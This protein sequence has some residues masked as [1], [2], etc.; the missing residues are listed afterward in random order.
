MRKTYDFSHSRSNPYAERLNVPMTSVI[1]SVPVKLESDSA[2]QNGMKDANDLHPGPVLVKSHIP[3]KTRLQTKGIPKQTDLF[4]ADEAIMSHESEAFLT[5]QILTYIGNKRTLLDF[6]GKGVQRAMQDLGKERLDI[7]DVFAGSGIVSRYLKQFSNTLF[8]C[9]LEPYSA[10]IN[11]CYLSNQSEIDSAL[12]AKAIKTINDAAKKN[13]RPGF[14][15][16]LYAPQN[17]QDIKLGERVFYTRR[18]AM[19]IDTSRQLIEELLPPEMQR[20]ALAPLLYVASVH[21][22]TSGVFKGFYKNSETGIGQ[23]GGNGKD[24]LTRICKDFEIPAPLFSQHECQYRVYQGNSNELAKTIPNIDLAYLDPPYNQHPY[25]SNYF[26]LNLIAKNRR[27]DE[28]SSVSGI[29]TDWNR[30]DYNKRPLAKKALRE[31]VTSIRAKYLLISFNSEGFIKHEEMK[32]MLSE[33]GT[34]ESIETQYNTFRGSRNLQDR[35]IHVKEY[36]YLVK[37]GDSYVK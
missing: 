19:M 7:F 27:P 23:F 14:I 34:T 20:Y 15:T 4:G 35:S 6:I 21:A 18:N 32:E 33:I 29:P 12:I 26:M 1:T 25:G 36:L 22:N 2:S 9:D 24:A 17:D 28:T 11:S 5:E 13:L 30:S 31:L 10:I 8:T 3:A 16:E 37:K